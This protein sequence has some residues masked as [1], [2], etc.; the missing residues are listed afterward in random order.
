MLFDYNGECVADMGVAL[1][2]AQD[3]LRDTVAAQ[4]VLLPAVFTSDIIVPPAAVPAVELDAAAASCASRHSNHG[5]HGRLEQHGRAGSAAGA[6]SSA[7]R[8]AALATA[9]VRGGRASR[10]ARRSGGRCGGQAC[11]SVGQ[12]STGGHYHLAYGGGALHH[13]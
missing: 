13:H 12:G 7:A 2:P 4:K 10:A 3:W 11:T 1:P 9:G 8:T 5:C 6:A